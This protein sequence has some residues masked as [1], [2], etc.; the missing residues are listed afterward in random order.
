MILGRL[1]YTT[2]PGYV[3]HLLQI[4]DAEGDM[5]LELAFK[6]DTANRALVALTPEEKAALEQRIVPFAIQGIEDL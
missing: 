5:P 4:D 2:P 3:Q 1:H 6:V